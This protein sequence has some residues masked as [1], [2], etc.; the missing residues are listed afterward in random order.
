MNKGR[1]VENLSER[2]GLSGLSGA[3]YDVVPHTAELSQNPGRSN[4]ESFNSNLNISFE[5]RKD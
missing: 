2:S 5:E 4:S 1:N 3:H